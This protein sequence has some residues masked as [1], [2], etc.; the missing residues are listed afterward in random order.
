MKYLITFALLFIISCQSNAHNG[1][2]HIDSK[3][4]VKETSD[5]LVE[6]L[7]AKGM[8]IFNR[9][10]HSQAAEKV[11]IDLKETTL[12]IFGNPKIGSLLMKCSA[13]IAIDLPQKMLITEEEDGMVKISY[14][15]PTYLKK[16]HQMDDCNG[17][18]AKV[19]KAL[20]NFAKAAAN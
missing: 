12:V 3:H 14:N 7:R 6:I 8:T 10:E 15:D 1:L 13:H 11:G 16:R 17:V 9:I 19:S 18:I 2:I 5:K 4:S 20:N